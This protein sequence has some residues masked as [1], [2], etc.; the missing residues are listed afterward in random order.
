MQATIHSIPLS[1][2]AL[3]LGPVAAVIAIYLR[4]SLNSLA[5]LLAI[6]RMVVQLLLIGYVLRYIF[7][8]EHPLV[9]IGVLGVMLCAAS[10]I[11]VRPVKNHQPQLYW[12]MLAAIASG[13]VSTLIVVTQIVLPLSSWYQPNYVIPLAGMIFSNSMNAVSLAAERF[14]AELERTN[15]YLLARNTAFNAALIPITNTLL[16]VGLVSLPGMMTGQIL[17]G[18]SPLLAVRYQ[19]VVMCMVFSS[20]GISAACYLWLR[21]PKVGVDNP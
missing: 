7:E 14:E 19:I 20:A 6:V 2:V 1:S 5:P 15:D 21:A 16:A 3:M 4:W 9:V 13:G 18:V 17:S 8:T 12:V 10:W 11:A